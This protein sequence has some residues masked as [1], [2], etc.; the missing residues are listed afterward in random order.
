VVRDQIRD[1][2]PY[3]FED[4]G[5]QSVKNI[6]RP[7][8]VYALRR[9]AVADLPASSAPLATSV[10]QSTRAPRL[11]IVVLPFAN[12]SNDPEQGYF[13][14]GITD[15]LTTD[16]S[17]IAGMFVISRN[18][19]FS[20]RDKSVGAKQIGR[21]L[22][23]R[24]VL[25]GT[26]RRS[27]NQV[28]VNA[29]LVDAETEAHLWAEQIDRDMGALLALQT[30]IT[31]RIAVALNLE[32]VKAEAA[33]PTEHPDALDYLFRGRAAFYKPPSRD[34]HVEAIR[35]F[36]LALALD[37]RSVEAQSW[38]AIAIVSQVLDQLANSPAD[39][40]ARAEELAGR[41]LAASPRSPLAHFARGLVLR[42]QH[43]NEEAILEYEMAIAF[44]R[45][46]PSAYAELGRCKFY[47]GSIEEMIP[48]AEQAIR[49]SPRDHQ[50]GN[51][52]YRIGVEHLLQSRTDEAI[53]WLEKARIAAPAKPFDHF[54]LAAAYALGGDLD[55]AA[56]ELAE[57]RRLRGEGS[58]SSIAKM[59]R[60]VWRS[61]SPKT[62]ALYE[63]TYF[64][65]L[66]KAGMPEE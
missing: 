48:L 50:N 63:A 10:S 53:V 38:L 19:A 21:E 16:L 9:G 11:S 27:D 49:L 65:G 34:K 43:Q 29:Q 51:W 40:V 32:F 15:D 25:D 47:T 45:N 12:L 66:R 6:A 46:W 58:F 42:A 37:P 8:R 57:A 7:V 30:E 56:T 22:G 39:D 55:R 54:H 1:K 44:K 20:Y 3:P 60:G 31:S 59:K 33:R 41:A 36:E 26:V 13:A 5:E 61:L 17:R 24:Y 62:R 4:R 23:V 52:Y 35:L 28:R 18:T 14:D 64:A 2:L